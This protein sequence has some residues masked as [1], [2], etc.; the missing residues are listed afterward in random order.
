MH[1]AEVFFQKLAASRDFFVSAD[2]LHLMIA[3]GR[4]KSVFSPRQPAHPGS[5]Q[6][7][8]AH[9]GMPASAMRN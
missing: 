4:R 8:S 5:W 1:F 9:G 7:K 2:Q 3:E 6:V